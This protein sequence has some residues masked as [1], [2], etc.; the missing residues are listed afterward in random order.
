MDPA[1][2]M[3]LMK[4]NNLDDSKERVKDIYIYI[5]KKSYLQTAA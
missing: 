1:P 4:Q 5:K 2:E 3:P